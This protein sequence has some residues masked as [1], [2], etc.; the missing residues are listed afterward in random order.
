MEKV[1][2]GGIGFDKCEKHEALD[3]LADRIEKGQKTMIVTPNAEIVYSCRKDENLRRLVNSA[4]MV[5]PD[6]IG[7]V[8]ASKIL[9]TPL[10]HRIAGIDFAED[11]LRYASS[12]GLPVFLLGA[13]DGVAEKAAGRIRE[14]Y[15][16]INICG[17]NNGYFSDKEQV[18]EKINLSGAKILFVCL[19]FPMQELFMKEN[20]DKINVS[21]M[22]GLGGSLDVFSGEVQ[23]APEIFINCGLEWL[24]RL[25]KQPS[26]IGRMMKLP[27]FLGGIIKDR[28][29]ES[30][31]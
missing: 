7:V 6:G 21:T 18:A 31:K 9:G 17:T 24:Y 25:I 15:P 12:K 16:G 8:Y 4:D 28:L 27:L 14:R 11:I 23:R 19:G 13:K 2:V 30:G 1:I 22:I 10:K 26:R 29:T 20:Y 5:L 3:Y